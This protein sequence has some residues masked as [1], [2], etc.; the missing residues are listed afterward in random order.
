MK[1]Q[2]G[3]E[4]IVNPVKTVADAHL[5]FSWLAFS[6]NEAIASCMSLR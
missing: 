5:R 3:Y 4:K 6:L 2:K 1:M